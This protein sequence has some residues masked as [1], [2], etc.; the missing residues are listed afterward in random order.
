[1]KK[2]ILINFS[3][4]DI[5]ILLIKQATKSGSDIRKIILSKNVFEDVLF[6]DYSAV[7]YIVIYEKSSSKNR[8]NLNIIIFLQLSYSK[9]IISWYDN[10]GNKYIFIKDK[11]FY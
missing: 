7:Q 2:I 1:M 3:R 9:L 10:R 5:I 11:I 6:C 4:Y 8:F